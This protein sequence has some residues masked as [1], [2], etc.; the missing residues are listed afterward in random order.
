MLFWITV[1]IVIAALCGLIAFRMDVQDSG[2]GHRVAL[3]TIIYVVMMTVSTILILGL[4][5]TV[6]TSL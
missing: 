6:Q 4:D 1:A 5:K 2:V 3:F